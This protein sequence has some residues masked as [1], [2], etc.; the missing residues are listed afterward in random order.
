MRFQNPPRDSLSIKKDHEQQKV[1]HTRTQSVAGI[2][3]W[4]SVMRIVADRAV[5]YVAV[6]RTVEDHGPS[7]VRSLDSQLFEVGSGQPA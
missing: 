2:S 7:A 3:Q 6:V 1:G 5:E 4:L